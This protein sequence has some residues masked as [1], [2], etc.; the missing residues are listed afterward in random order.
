MREFFRDL[1]TE[2]T[3]IIF[4][5][6]RGKY[7][8][9]RRSN[10]DVVFRFNLDVEKNS[11]FGKN[12]SFRVIGVM[13]DSEVRVT[14]GPLK[15]DLFLLTQIDSIDPLLN[16]GSLRRRLCLGIGVFSVRVRGGAVVG[17]RLQKSV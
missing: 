1:V 7:R 14:N 2:P 4:P 16:V 11:P 5:Q 8:N 15:G 9:S 12:V 10:Y 13:N 6:L 17:R 3:P